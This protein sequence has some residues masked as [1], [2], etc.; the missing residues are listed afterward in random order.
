MDLTAFPA[1]I[2]EKF[3]IHNI[4]PLGDHLQSTDRK[5][6][7]AFVKAVNNAKSNVADLGL[8][9]RA[10][11]SSDPSER[12]EAVEYGRHWIEVAALIGSP[13]VRQHVAGKKGQTPNVELAAESL[14]KVADYGAKHHV[15]V[16]LENDSPG[17]ED[18]FFLVKVIERANHPYLRALPDF[19]NSLIGHDAEYN[20]RAVAGMLRH[21]FNMSHVKS[22]VESDSGSSQD[23]D[24][25]ALF[26]LARQLGFKGY[27]CMEAET[28]SIDPFTGTKQ[29]IEKTV[30]LL[31]SE[32][33]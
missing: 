30:E 13:S 25:K 24:L 26:A 33:K 29:L 19:G 22:Q 16:N 6:L 15:V 2:A 31:T 1:M 17:P 21:A 10:F 27:F 8:G 9:G 3:G 28:K 32:G 11:Y 12:A 18:A 20:A 7:E 5:Y 14:A 4:N 23:V